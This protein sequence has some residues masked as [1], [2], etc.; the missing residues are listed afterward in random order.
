M[1][2]FLSNPTTLLMSGGLIAVVVAS[3]AHIKAFLG[4]LKSY[5]VV[6]A[7]M[8]DGSTNAIMAYARANWHMSRFGLRTYAAWRLFVRPKRRREWVGMEL[9]GKET[10]LFWRGWLPIW[11][12]RTSTS[13]DEESTTSVIYQPV[14]ITFF[15]GTIKLDDVAKEAVAFFNELVH[16]DSQGSR[17]RV[18]YVHGSG[19]KPA[20]IS[21]GG[22]TEGPSP[23]DDD[24]AED[25]LVR[26][27][28]NRLLSWKFHEI[29][30]DVYDSGK[31][32]DRL[33]LN[34][35]SALIVKQIGEWLRTQEWHRD[36]GVPWKRGYGLYGPPGTGKTALVRALGED[37]DLPI[38]VFDLATLHN[39][40]LREGWKNM[41]AHTPCIGLIE[42]I[43]SVF[44]KRKTLQGGHLTF[45]SLL[46]C[47]DGV[48]RSDGLL[49]FVT[50]NKPEMLDEALGGAQAGGLATRPGRI[51]L[52]VELG[53]LPEC[54]RQQL[55]ERIL[56]DL[57]PSIRELVVKQ[58]DGDTGAQFERRCVE[59]ATAQWESTVDC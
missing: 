23:M 52:A 25:D 33:Y 18:Y 28:G 8:V 43:D 54:G 37:Y 19:N 55:V 42:D 45:D 3:W 53:N 7:E 17:Y 57:D 35:G 13:R 47:I 1:E 50:T 4:H 49:T 34:E 59:C 51:D 32:L 40:E 38:Y 15:R 20:N 39:D 56:V 14:R 2:Q 11:I 22:R 24:D 48:E 58:G 6:S 21:V 26:V 10:K 27:R 31:A 30:P 44:D 41:L 29:G 5:V 9:I 16:T 36:R 12:T 46:N